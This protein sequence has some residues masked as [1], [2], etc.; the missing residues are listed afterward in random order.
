MNETK[1]HLEQNCLLPF[2]FLEGLK[3]YLLSD[4]DISDLKHKTHSFVYLCEIYHF[5]INLL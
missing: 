4:K 3:K 2:R 1:C 5:N